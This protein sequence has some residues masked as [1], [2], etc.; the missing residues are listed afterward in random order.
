MDPAVAFGRAPYLA[1][2]PAW[3]D[4]QMNVSKAMLAEVYRAR[5][6]DRLAAA[7]LPLLVLVGA[8]DLVTPPGSLR[9]GFDR[10]GAPKSFVEMA[11]SHHLP[12]VDEPARFAASV[13][14]FAREKRTP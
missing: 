5:T 6:S 10:W 3:V 4:G 2:D 11:Q 7:T 8:R 14:A 9:D 12:F 13:M 1:P